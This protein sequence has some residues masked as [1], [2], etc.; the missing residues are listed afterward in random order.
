MAEIL[1][2]SLG[3][4]VEL[5]AGAGVF[6]DVPKDTADAVS[7]LAAPVTIGS[8]ISNG[9]GFGWVGAIGSCRP[10]LAA[11]HKRVII[12]AAVCL[13]AGYLEHLVSHGGK[14]HESVLWA[15]VDCAIIHGALLAAGAKPGRPVQFA[16]EEPKREFKP[17]SGTRIRITL[18]YDDNGQIRRVPAQ[19]WIRYAKTKKLLDQ[20]W[21]FAGSYEFKTP[22][23]QV[24]YAANEGRYICVANFANAMLDLPFKSQEGDPQH[25]LDFEVNTESLPRQLDSFIIL[26]AFQSA[27]VYTYPV[28][29]LLTKV[30]I[31]LE[32]VGVDTATP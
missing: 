9:C 31:I 6:L 30:L 20:D 32:P 11:K 13:R 3:R 14:R 16:S 25:G 19:Q 7:I 21:V 2:Q 4:R 12:P 10:L 15:D 27:Y 8:Y 17:P 28:P 5:G 29:P 24:V 23:G 22:D 1:A 18:E 26:G